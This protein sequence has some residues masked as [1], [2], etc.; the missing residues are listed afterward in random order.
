MSLDTERESGCGVLA[1]LSVRLAP[2]ARYMIGSN[3]RNA[4]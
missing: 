2:F 3:R 1:I 4:R